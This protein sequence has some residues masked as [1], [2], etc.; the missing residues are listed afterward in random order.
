[1]NSADEHPVLGDQP[2]GGTLA[3]RTS[4]RGRWTSWVGVVVM[5]AGFTAAGLGLTLGPSWALV[6]GGSVAFL[7]GGAAALALGILRDVVLDEPR[8]E[9][10]EPHTTP[11]HREP[12]T[13]PVRTRPQPPR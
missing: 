11:L 9:R 1:M 3:E 4:H 13:D 6:V 2:E 7:A 5:I 8:T 12:A 10:E